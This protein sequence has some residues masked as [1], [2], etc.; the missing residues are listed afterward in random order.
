MHWSGYASIVVVVVVLMWP[1]PEPDTQEVFEAHF[2]QYMSEE[3]PKGTVRLCGNGAVRCVYHHLP[4]ILWDSLAIQYD[5]LSA[6][7]PPRGGGGQVEWFDPIGT[8]IP[9]SMPMQTS[10]SYIAKERGYAW[11]LP[12]FEL[13]STMKVEREHGQPLKIWQVA[14]KPR[15]YLVR[16][17]FEEKVLRELK[18]A[19]ILSGFINSSMYNPLLEGNVTV[20]HV[21]EHGLLPERK[22][23]QP[24]RNS[25][26][27][28][29][30]PE[31]VP[32][33]IEAERVVLDT[34]LHIEPHP[35]SHVEV[36]RFL[37]GQHAYLHR[38][39]DGDDPI[40]LTLHLTLQPAESGG[41][42]CFPTAQAP[43]PSR[44]MYKYRLQGFRNN[45]CGV[46]TC[47]ESK[48]GDLLIMYHMD[49]MKQPQLDEWAK[50]MHCDVEL[51]EKL[52]VTRHFSLP[53]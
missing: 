11:V 19:A 24:G 9:T 38:I 23:R 29:L 28:I 40:F 2:P 13:N 50:L 10:G 8:K 36:E 39:Q 43:F 49:P 47:L 18:R 12:T 14:Q 6:M 53:Q 27:S 46:G 26:V 22:Y 25:H 52:I 37:R 44:R 33:Y 45:V 21:L 31:K 34:L 32:R 4:G 1:D 20:K 3:V 17:V 5:L 41:R 30:K 42:V 48:R 16:G 35:F 7:S 15:V 51:G